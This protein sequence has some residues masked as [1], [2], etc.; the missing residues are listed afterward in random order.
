[1]TIVRWKAPFGVTTASSSSTAINAAPRL[2]LGFFEHEQEHGHRTCG[3][4]IWARCQQRW[5]AATPVHQ[6]YMNDESWLEALPVDSANWGL[7]CWVCRHFAKGAPGPFAG[8]GV[9]C[10]FQKKRLVDHQKS[11]RHQGAVRALLASRGLAGEDHLPAPRITEF[12]DLLQR[13]RRG[14]VE[15]GKDVAQHKASTMSWCLYEAYREAERKFLAKATCMSLA[16]DASTRGPYLLTR[17]VACGPTLERR[18]GVLMITDQKGSGAADLA[19]SVIRSIRLGISVKGHPHPSTYTPAQPPERLQDFAKHLESI[20]EVFVADGAA[21]EQLAGRMLQGG[22]VRRTAEVTGLPNLKLV[23]R[24]KPHSARRLLQRTLPKDAYIHRLLSLLLWSKNSLT[25]LI[26]HSACH[27]EAF[28]RHQSRQTGHV[29][30]LISN[31]SYAEQRF[32]SLCRPLGRLVIHFDAIVM[33]AADVISERPRSSPEHQAAN[34]A[35]EELD[36]EAMLQI[37]MVADACEIV[38]RLVRFLDRESFD[39]AELPSQ[40]QAFKA[41]AVELFHR[42][43]C[44]THCGFAKCMLELIRKPRLVHLSNG[45]P[46]T[47]GHPDGAEPA[48]IDACLGRMVNWWRLAEEVLRTD[49]PDWDI[50]MSFEVFQVPRSIALPDSTKAHLARLAEFFDVPTDRVTQEYLLMLPVA[51]QMARTTAGLAA[52]T[53]CDAWARAVQHTQGRADNR[54]RKDFP[55]KHLCQVLARYTAYAAATSGVE[56]QFSQ[57]VALFHHLRNFSAFG[58]QRILVLAGS[59]GQTTEEDLDLCVRARHIWVD[60]F[61]APRKKRTFTIQRLKTLQKRASKRATAD[62]EAARSRRFH[63]V[64]NESVCRAQ[65]SLTRPKDLDAVASRLWSQQQEGELKRQR[66]LQLARKVEAVAMGALPAGSDDVD[67]KVLA[68]HVQKLGKTHEEYMRRRHHLLAGRQRRSLDLEPGTRVFVAKDCSCH[69]AKLQ[70]AFVQRQLQAELQASRA[71]VF[72]VKDP[73]DPPNIVGLAAA[74]TGGLLVSAEF[75]LAPPGTAVRYAR[76]LQIQRVLWI[77]PACAT[78]SPQTVDLISRI[79]REGRSS[80]VTCKWR[81]MED[82]AEFCGKAEQGGRGHNKSR[83]IALVAQGEGEGAGLQGVLAQTLT[84]FAELHTRVL[85][86]GGLSGVCGR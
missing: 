29:A 32:D 33:T 42:R 57:Y 23:I 39:L 60:N 2:P 54:L 78:Q 31:L 37:G 8:F 59:R 4:C 12:Q 16:Q 20:T 17:Y 68:E 70:A 14:E 18:A 55:C 45:R 34:A 38:L 77:S 73:A 36:V 69:V 27:S 85:A 44:L 6:R 80:A 26:Q 48:T 9:R 62:S 51:N 72:V 53:S 22:S 40:L 11:V 76:A 15:G 75:F 49:F 5:L 30:H 83:Y 52:S 67:E 47:I 21:D 86:D 41:S 25:R 19:C 13:V 64:L 7:G 3:R 82:Q 71:N 35:L 50:L 46:K 10:V 65:G 43:G 61:G 66:K 1:M 28:K 79:V 74:L 58:I 81:I 24:D 84:Q 56:Q 63:K